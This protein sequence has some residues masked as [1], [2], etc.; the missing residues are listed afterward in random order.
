MHLPIE[1][2]VSWSPQY[3]AR[4]WKPI[5][6]SP[7]NF[8]VVWFHFL[9]GSIMYNC[10]N[11]CFINAHSKGYSSDYTLQK[12]TKIPNIKV[13][14]IS[15]LMQFSVLMFDLHK[16]FLYYDLSMLCQTQLR[17]TIFEFQVLFTKSNTYVKMPLLRTRIPIKVPPNVSSSRKTHTVM[18][19]V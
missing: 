7:S 8:L 6:T 18:W 15:V 19:T 1:A 3:I 11:V 4:G 13:T 16:V 14:F 5:T 9:W 2:H 17:N 10:P 12:R